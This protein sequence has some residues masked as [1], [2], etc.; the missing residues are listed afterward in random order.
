MNQQTT[1]NRKPQAYN[2][3]PIMD[4]AGHTIGHFAGTLTPPA[5]DFGRAVDMWG[6]ANFE[7]EY[8]ARRTTLADLVCDMCAGGDRV[9]RLVKI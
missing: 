7:N 2:D 3:L 6:R 4:R 1:T 9:W 8:D 5:K